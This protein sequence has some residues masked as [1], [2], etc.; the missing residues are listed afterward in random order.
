MHDIIYVDLR[1][2]RGVLFQV[3]FYMYTCV[4]FM[5][6][7]IQ[8]MYIYL[9]SEVCADPAGPLTHRPP[10][11]STGPSVGAPAAGCAGIGGVDTNPT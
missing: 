7:L 3:A 4:W 11:L 10:R 5:C 9:V 1:N 8:Q 2:A 6:I